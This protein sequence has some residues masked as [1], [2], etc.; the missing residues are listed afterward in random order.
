MLYSPPSPESLAQLKA[1]LGLSSAQMA[2][3][4]GVS[5]GRQWRKY[6]GGER[7]MSAQILFFALARLELD[8]AT[9]EK[10]LKRMRKIG[11]TIELSG[12]ESESDS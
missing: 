3:L 5:D 8:E 12:A 9:I 7:D 6:T 1:D 10:V 4:F 2:Q 11:A